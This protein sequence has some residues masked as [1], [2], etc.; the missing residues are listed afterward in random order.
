MGKLKSKVLQVSAGGGGGIIEKWFLSH[1]A[2]IDSNLNPFLVILGQNSIFVE[3]RAEL[4]RPSRQT[5]RA[6]VPQTRKQMAKASCQRVG[7]LN[8]PDLDGGL[9]TNGLPQEPWDHRT[10]DRRGPQGS[11]SPHPSSYR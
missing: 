7:L 1:D 10:L 11:R 5:N 2:F 8:G 6:A 3:N 4:Q 9:R